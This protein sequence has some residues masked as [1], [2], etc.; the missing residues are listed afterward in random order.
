VLFLT[1]EEPIVMLCQE[2]SLEDLKRQGFA[3]ELKLDGT[4]VKIV[5]EN[6][7][8]TLINR[9]QII[10]NARLPE[11]TEAVKAIPADNFVLDSEIVYINPAT[12]QSEFTPCQRRCS[13]QD[14]GKV[15][16]LQRLYPVKAMVFDIMMVDGQD[17]T[18]TPYYQRKKILWD[19]LQKSPTQNLLYVP[20]SLNL[21]ESWNYV[22]QRGEEGLILK[23]LD[24]PY[25]YRRS[26]NW[27]KVKN[28]R[29][30]ICTVVGY[31]PGEGSRKWA[32]GSLVLADEKGNYCG[33]V[34]S[35]FSELDLYRIKKILDSAPKT[36]KPFPTEIV[37]E[38]YTAVSPIL[39]I[40]IK[41]YKRNE[42]NIYRFP[43]FQKI[44]EES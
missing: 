42:S 7:K 39:K 14:I 28:W 6:G 18:A 30:T 29:E 43:V 12:G 20:Y 3:A 33:C 24:S 11:I 32:F 8:V 2:G 37:G 22:T 36:G 27:L 5:K 10:Y 1:E 19:F 26:F 40:K 31:T 15:L 23:R 9:R 25:E 21:Q 41:Y 17:L 38:D 35:G 13:T 16:F 4:R 34:G 44:Y